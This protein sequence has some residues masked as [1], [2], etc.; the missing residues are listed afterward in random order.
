MVGPACPGRR[1]N[2]LSSITVISIRQNRRAA[3]AVAFAHE[4]PRPHGRPILTVD[5]FPVPALTNGTADF[6]TSAHWVARPIDAAVGSIDEA[7][8]RLQKWFSDDELAAEIAVAVVRASLFSI[9]PLHG[10]CFVP[11]VVRVSST[12]SEM[13]RPQEDRDWDFLHNAC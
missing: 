7:M 3:D 11:G 2:A 10:R 12:C 5:I 8:A 13:K 1:L 9:F 6:A 4:A